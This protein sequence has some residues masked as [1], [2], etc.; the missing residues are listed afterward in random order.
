MI[1][2]PSPVTTLS[3]FDQLFVSN[4]ILFPGNNLNACAYPSNGIYTLRSPIKNIR[5]NID[6]KTAPIESAIVN[7]AFRQA[8]F[9][10]GS[11]VKR[12]IINCVDIDAPI[13]IRIDAID[14]SSELL[15]PYIIRNARE[16]L[17]SDST[18]ALVFSESMAAIGSLF[19]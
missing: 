10:I 12:I 2:N 8:K 17:A 4:V 3:A 11:S 14:S 9:P 1:T 5:K 7:E 16:L 15:P 19:Q 18:F 6:E 13:D